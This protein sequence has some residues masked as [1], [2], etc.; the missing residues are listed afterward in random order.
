MLFWICLA[1]L[2]IGIIGRIIYNDTKY[3][4]DVLN[5]LSLL[6]M[7]IGGGTTAIAIIVLVIQFVAV[8]AYIARNTSRYES[9]IYQY[10]NDVYDNDNDLG[11]R[12]LIV[13]IQEW[14]EDLSWYREAEDDFWIGIFIPNVHDQFEFIELDKGE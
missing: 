13:G 3:G 12:E 9:L 6:A 11:K 4:D 2:V 1:I 5:E 10:D 8:D 14:N 7:V